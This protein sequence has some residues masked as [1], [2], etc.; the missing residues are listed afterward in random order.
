MNWRLIHCL[1]SGSPL[2]MTVYDAAAWS[3]AFPLSVA[4]VT[5]GSSP[6]S[7]PD[8]TR[9]QWKTPRPLLATAEG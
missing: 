3:S 2:D 1:R 9:G 7:V 6:V 8:F 5:K 4:S